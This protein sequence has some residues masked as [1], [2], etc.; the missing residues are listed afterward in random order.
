MRVDTFK[1][2]WR[3]RDSVYYTMYLQFYSVFD[4]KLVSWSTFPV[5]PEVTENYWYAGNIAFGNLRPQTNIQLYLSS[6]NVGFEFFL[7]MKMMLYS[8]FWSSKNFL[9]LGL[10][11][12]YY[13]YIYI[14]LASPAFAP[15][16]N[17]EN[18]LIRFKTSA[19]S[20]L[21]I[22]TTWFWRYTKTKKLISP[23]PCISL[24]AFLGMFVL[25]YKKMQESPAFF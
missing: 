9:N 16:G 18:F 6:R 22:S 2:Q 14:V 15:L 25:F 11:D 20:Y 4:L 13:I 5:S 19:K 24:E 7:V 8:F 17:F 12:Q 3:Y 10:Q 23:T 1:N 21:I